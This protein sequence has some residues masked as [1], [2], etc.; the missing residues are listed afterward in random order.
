MKKI[1]TAVLL[2]HFFQQSCAQNLLPYVQPLSGTA[3]STTT[4]AQKH[5]EAGSERNANTIPAV[6]LPFGLTQWTAQTR[7][8]EQKCNPP[9]FYKD[10]LLSG[11]RGTHWISGSCM[12]DYGSVTIMPV[13][14]R[15]KTKDYAVPF[16]HE[17]EVATPA[18]YKVGLPAL[19]L[20]AEM[21]ATTRCGIL[22]FTVQQV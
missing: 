3:P 15:L 9:Y 12:Q 19:Q 2:L 5:S 20:T 8:T 21:S 18:W 1:L 10:S 17:N 7:T 4:A 11:F 6:G 16:S 13:T 22:Q 14:G